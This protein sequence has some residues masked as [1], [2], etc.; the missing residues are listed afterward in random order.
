[1]RTAIFGVGALGTVLGAYLNR[2]GLEVDLIHHNP[3]TVKAL[4]EKGARVVGT[5]G[6]VQKVKALTPEEMTGKYDIIILLTNTR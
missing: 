2:S 5:V 6:F 1:M 4:N 3:A